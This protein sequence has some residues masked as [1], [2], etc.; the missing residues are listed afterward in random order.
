MMAK[1]IKAF[2]K[3]RE[4][5]LVSHYKAPLVLQEKTF[6]SLIRY[7]ISTH[8]G[9]KYHFKNIR[10]PEDFNRCV[11]V[12][13]YEDLLPYFQDILKGKPSV[14]WPGKV[15]WFAK[16]SGST[17]AR[18]KYIPVTREA[19][20]HCH[21]KAAKDV[22]TLYLVHRPDSR[23]FSGKG[24]VL[25]G[26]SAVHPASYGVRSG[27][28]SAVLLHNS[29]WYSRWVRTP[30]N[31]VALLGDWEKKMEIL[32][33]LLPR[34][35]ITSLSGVPSWMLVLL[36]KILSQNKLDT[37]ANLWPHLELYIH[38]AV[39]FAPY[40]KRY[41]EIFS[42]LK[43][44]F[45]ET[46]N[47]SE[48]FFAIQDRPGSDEMLL[49]LDHGVYY[50]FIPLEELSKDWPRAYHLGEVKTGV[51][52]AMVIST[53]GGLWR[54]LIGDTI[55]FTS[56]QPYRIQITGR[57]KHFINVFGEELVVE[58]AERA[59]AEASRQLGLVVTDFTAGPLYMQGGKAGAH[60]WFVEFATP[61]AEIQEFS[62]KLDQELRKLNS[63]YDAK[64]FGDLALGPPVVHAVPRGTFEKWLRKHNRLGGQHKVPRLSNE[65][66]IIDEILECM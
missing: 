15:S 46:Y 6:N 47:A 28:L 66:K 17:D 48:G 4:A 19:L 3:L 55:R 18:S 64:R 31:K 49:L 52:Y 56:I 7:G 30:S 62:E 43:V 24:F 53:N 8:F 44:W 33:R 60:E 57:T 13:R 63:D 5:A 40:K 16:S 58:N 41:E 10:T 9:Y 34:Q 21:F 38:G 12:H 14:L 36:E 2:L 26:S 51:S 32:I 11:P 65:R 45:L 27:D 25:G 29:P 22:L 1:F 42:G 50:E 54:Y 35:N 37:V 23:L 39:S 61:P 59:I 20:Y